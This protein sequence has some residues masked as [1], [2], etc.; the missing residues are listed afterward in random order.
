MLRQALVTSLPFYFT[1]TSPKG[2]LHPP[3]TIQQIK[4]SNIF[5]YAESILF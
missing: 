3:I 2:I 5:I 4:H 1:F